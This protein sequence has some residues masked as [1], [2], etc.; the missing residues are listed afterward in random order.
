MEFLLFAL[1][2]VYF[3]CGILMYVFYIVMAIYFSTKFITG[4][5][6]KSKAKKGEDHFNPP[7]AI[8]IPTAIVLFAIAIT[9]TVYLATH[10]Y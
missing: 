1:N 4:L 6:A 9:G 3:A 2:K 7:D 8:E 5:V 10:I